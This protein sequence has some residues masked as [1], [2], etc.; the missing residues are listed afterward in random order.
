MN[1]DGVKSAVA[2]ATAV[3]ELR[4]VA[5]LLRVTH[6][7]AGHEFTDAARAEAYTWLDQH[8]KR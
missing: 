7:D 1:V 8:L 5:G 3:Y 6:P 4:R 2:S